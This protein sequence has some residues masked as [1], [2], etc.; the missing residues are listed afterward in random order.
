MKLKIANFLISIDQWFIDRFQDLEVWAS[1]KCYF[2]LA[3]I[4]SNIAYRFVSG[5]FFR[6][7]F[8]NKK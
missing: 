8:W 2:G 7:T 4:F 1:E 6:K 5:V 3:I